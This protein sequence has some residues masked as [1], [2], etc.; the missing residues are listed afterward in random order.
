MAW[1]TTGAFRGKE[2]RGCDTIG[3]PRLKGTCL[4]VT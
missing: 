4:V 1:S 2:N 3:V